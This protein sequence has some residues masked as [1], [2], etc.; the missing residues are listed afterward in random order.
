MTNKTNPP[1]P[2]EK[3]A[4]CF[5]K[6]LPEVCPL[7]RTKHGKIFEHA[8]SVELTL[9]LNT[10]ARLLEKMTPEQRERFDAAVKDRVVV[11]ESTGVKV[12]APRTPSETITADLPYLINAIWRALGLAQEGG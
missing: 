5:E 11:W 9:N 12:M 4:A 6:L 7:H 10:I 1:T 2:L 8:S 3:L